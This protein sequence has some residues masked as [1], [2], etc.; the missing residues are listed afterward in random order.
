[1]DGFDDA[2][3][4]AYDAFPQRV[5]VI[6]KDGKV[7]YRSTGLVGFGVEEVERVLRELNR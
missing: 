7:A 2:M 6:G 4:R 5:Y 3:L 1:M